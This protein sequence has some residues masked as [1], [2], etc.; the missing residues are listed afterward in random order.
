MS[1]GD[2]SPRSTG[3]HEH[4][5]EHAE[6]PRTEEPVAEAEKEQAVEPEQSEAA[7]QYFD[8]L[9]F[10]QDKTGTTKLKSLLRGL[11]NVIVSTSHEQYML[12]ADDNRMNA[13]AQQI[14]PIS[15]LTSW[16]ISI[17]M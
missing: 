2:I 11:K 15:C 13:T 14:V 12:W 10:E 4:G 9:L 17:K 5:N 7:D 16:R 3:P 6:A 8:G 1:E